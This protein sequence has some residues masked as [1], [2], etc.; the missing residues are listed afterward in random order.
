VK[1][2]KQVALL[3]SALFVITVKLSGAF[4][5]QGTTPPDSTTL[6][7]RAAAFNAIE[8]GKTF[9]FQGKVKE[10]LANFRE[11]TIKNPY[12]SKAFYWVA[13]CQYQLNNYG[14]SQKYATDAIM[15]DKEDVDG[16]VFELLAKAY[17]RLGQIDSALVNYNRAKSAMNARDAKNAFIDLHIAE[18]E[19]AKQEFGKGL[20]TE[21]KSLAT[22]NSPYNEYGPIITNNGKSLYLTG[23][24]NDTKGEGM[25]PDDQEYFEDIYKAVWNETSQN[26]D[27]LSNELGRINTDGF[28]A[29]TWIS[30]DGLHALM[31]INTTASGGKP[32]TESSDIFISEMSNKGRWSTPKRIANKTINT[33]YFDGAATMTADG[34]TMYFVSDRNGEESY[35]DIFVVSKI[36]EKTWGEAKALPASINSPKAETT[37]Y[38]TPDGRYLFFASDGLGGLGGYDIYVT[39]NLGD[40]WSTPVNLGARFNTVNN[41]THFQYYPEL[42]KA[43]SAGFE[44]IGQKSS[45]NVYEFDMTNFTFPKQ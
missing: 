16:E 7:D 2:N 33:S 29:M 30:M 37:P 41:D 23:R 15:A 22:I 17:H 35:M 25:N 26:W 45:M 10:A 11:A 21:R 6:I 14:L 12:S 38:I 42:K 4:A 44:L 28:D 40:S 19:F 34:Q 36:D 8:K 32:E 13:T 43:V 1:I 31:T 27:S 39:E 5:G 20:N 24:K 18:C 3:L 9:Y